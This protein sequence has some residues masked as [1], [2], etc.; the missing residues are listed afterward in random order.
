[1]GKEDALIDDPLP[2][3]FAGQWWDPEAIMSGNG[4]EIHAQSIAAEDR[5]MFPIQPLFD[6]M[7][8]FIGTMLVTGADME[9]N[10]D[11][12]RNIKGYPDPGLTH[13]AGFGLEFIKLDIV[14]KKVAE[15]AVVQRLVELS[16][17]L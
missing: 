17:T 13:L 16:G 8:Q 12:C 5:D 1:M 14:G 9:G 3:A 11:T 4:I 7:Q 10:H 2:G 6:L 15:E